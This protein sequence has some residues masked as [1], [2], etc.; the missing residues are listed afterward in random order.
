[1]T[2]RNLTYLNFFVEPVLCLVSKNMIK[3]LTK[4]FANRKGS[5]IIWVSIGKF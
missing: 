5:M 3:E 4:E 2:Y 1:V